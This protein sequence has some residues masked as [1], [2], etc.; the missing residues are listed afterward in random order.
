MVNI[1]GIILP[2]LVL[3]IVSYGIYK[4]VDIYDVFLEG[5]KES[6]DFILTM[7]PTMLGMILGVN[8]FLKSGFV[9][10]VFEY[11]DPLLKLLSLPL[12][13]LPM[14]FIRPISGSSALAIL[15]SLLKEK[16]PDSFIGRLASVMQG[17]TDT[18]FY[19]L[20]L[21]YGSVGIKKIK[22]SLIAGLG[23]DLAGIIG[24]IFITQMFFG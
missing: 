5:A 11:L 14:A 19:I 8:I 17:S 6:F 10:F 4:K 2:V 24:S 20:T 21:Y 9:N 18:T 1:S 13:V 16:G 12:E 22:Y 23:A 7:F 3:I 15:S